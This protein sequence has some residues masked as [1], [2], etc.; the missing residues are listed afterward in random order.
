MTLQRS[1]FSDFFCAVNHGHSAFRWQ[2]RLFETLAT[3]GRWPDRIVAPTSAGKSSVVDI[4]VFAVALSAINGGPRP[5]RRLALVVNRRALVDSHSQRAQH[6][7]QLL[8]DPLPGSL[9][10]QVADALHSLRSVEPTPPGVGPFDIVNLRGGIPPQRSWVAD[11]AACQVICAT[12][13]MWGSRILFRGYGTSNLARPRES[14]FLT[15]DAAMVLDEAHLNRQLLL[16]ARR[17]AELSAPGSTTLAIPGLQVVETTATPVGTGDSASDSE[18]GVIESDLGPDGDTALRMRLTRPKKVRRIGLPAWPPSRSGRERSIYID[19]L[20]EE[21]VRLRDTYGTCGSTGR[22]VGCF[23][24]T[25]SLAADVAAKLRKQGLATELLVGRLR[26]YD[27]AT[28]RQS[29]PNM[30]TTVGD[31]GVDVLIATQ[32]LE[33]GVDLDLA[34]LVTELAP[35]SAIAQRAGRVNRLGNAEGSEVVVLGPE[36]GSKLFTEKAPRTLAVPPYAGKG[37]A[38]AFELLRRTWDWLGERE[39]DDAGLSPWALVH[40]PPCAGRL[41]RILLQ[42]LELPDAW[43]LSRTSDEL[44]DEPDLELWLR[45]SLDPESASCGLVV[46]AQLPADDSAAIALLEATPPIDD[47]V[48]PALIQ[49]V[50]RVIS[51]ILSGADEYP[52]RAFR[53]RDN[54]ISAID[55]GDVAPGD[56]VIL[57]QGHLV[58]TSGVVVPSPTE[59]A[60]DVFDEVSPANV[61]LI[62]GVDDIFLDDLADLVQSSDGDVDDRDLIELLSEY[63]ERNGRVARFLDALEGSDRGLKVA[64]G[65][66]DVVE[67]RWL[68][69]SAP[70]PYTV[71][72]DTR[73]VWTPSPEPVLLDSHNA[74]VGARAREIAV[75]LGLPAD[76]QNV[77]DAGGR[78]HDAGKR[79]ERFQRIRLGN[80]DWQTAPLAKSHDNSMQRVSKK[81][82]LGGL[83]RKW[84]HEQLSAAIA[85]HHLERSPHNDLVMRLAGAS[86]GYGRPGFPHT[87]HD[88]LTE[89]TDPNIRILAETL[90]D[91]GGWD[92]LIEST[93]HRWGVW[94]CA[95]FEAILRAADSQVSAEGK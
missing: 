72:E 38:D 64:F 34:A 54:V 31:P 46:R 57:D 19:V 81:Q 8:H 27:L 89:D 35:A 82:A 93:H 36:P 18:I 92:T 26:A 24:N 91:E 85:A 10:R 84:R 63:R 94:A 48:F 60:A 70:R 78:F 61:R 1:D 40:S 73:Q 4:H 42:R 21:T 58:C 90:F 86:H 7:L 74:A 50:R 20:V 80:Q 87:T 5:P 2:H 83:P 16:T 3:S 47:E 79:D 56:V 23:V 41:S 68:A 30:F 53:F 75:R 49:D 67:N 22:T 62:A 6:I 12:P 11:P 88:L 55:A 77:L 51:L 66:F 71:A 43:Y 29:R 52:A 76:M 15:N 17:V 13:D 44:F 25:V 33:V 45:D 65:D 32:T 69:V 59:T 39:S 14:G 37:D 28:M 9:L 95:F